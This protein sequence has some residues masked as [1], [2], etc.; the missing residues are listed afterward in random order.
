MMN[1][2]VEIA[3]PF[4][5]V[6]LVLN[7]SPFS[8][9]KFNVPLRLP[10]RGHYRVGMTRIRI[11]DIFGLVP[12]RF[13]MRRLS[14]YRLKELL[15]LPK[16]SALESIQIE[17]IDAK[18]LGSNPHRSEEN[19]E[20]YSDSRLFRYG[21]PSK[22]ILWK[23]SFQQR[24]F[25]IR[26]YDVPAR[27]TVF[28]IIDTA[29]HNLNGIE[30]LKYADT[31]CEYAAT[32]C[33]NTIRFGKKARFFFSEFPDDSVDCDS[34]ERFNVF[35]E[36]LAYLPFSGPPNPEEIQRIL[37]SEAA[38]YSDILLITRDAGSSLISVLND[39]Q[40]SGKNVTLI[41]VGDG[42]IQSGNIRT[43]Y[44]RDN[45]EIPQLFDTGEK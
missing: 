1:I 21:D 11:N 36:K 37:L 15:V 7:L 16:V 14:Y 43:Q 24:R 28:A 3:S 33:L 27:E 34:I 42:S 18:I 17:Q 5:K 9:K 38:D 10:Y 25:Y 12:F 32:L 22:R 40:T 13:D 19:P 39:L 20:N 4:E 23:K 6:D 31:L 2:H 26:Q 41:I 44:I 35:R 29:A 30:L 45:E 8:G